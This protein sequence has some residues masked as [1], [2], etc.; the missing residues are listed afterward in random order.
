MTDKRF[1]KPLLEVPMLIAVIKLTD[2]PLFCEIF[3]ASEYDE[4]RLEGLLYDRYEGQG[5]WYIITDENFG[6]LMWLREAQQ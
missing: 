6:E 1:G 3:A 5:R 2:Q 4:G